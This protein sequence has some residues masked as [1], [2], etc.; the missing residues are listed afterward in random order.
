MASKFINGVWSMGFDMDPTV[1]AVFDLGTAGAMQTSPV[2]FGTGYSWNTGSTNDAGISL[3]TNLVTLILGIRAYWPTL[4]N[5]GAYSTMLNFYDLTGAASQVT[6]QVYSDGHFQFF[7]GSGTANPIGSAS[8]TGL[9][10]PGTWTYIEAKVTIDG[11]AGVVQLQVNGSSAISSSSL[12]TKATGN[13]WVSAIYL[14][15]P[16]SA[17]NYDDWYMLDMTAASPLNAFLGNV[18]VKGDKPNANSAV[19]GRNAFTPTNPTNVNYT[20]VGNIP[21]SASEYNSDATVGDYDMFRFPSLSA[22]SV[23]FI[24][25]FVVLELD[26]AGARTVELDCYSSGTDAAGSALTPASGSPSLYNQPYI[27]DPNTSAAWTVAAAQ[28]AELGVK[29]AS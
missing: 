18:Q 25:E 15:S 16:S 12:N 20:N 9:M 3:G 26:S 8:A 19:G 7:R 1:S 13:T 2:P 23:F 21:Y 5:S 17:S 4:P 14:P 11:S 22:A 6:L 10:R 27:V 29:I 24:N 28:A